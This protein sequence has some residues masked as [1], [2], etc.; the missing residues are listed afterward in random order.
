MW[1]YI[2]QSQYSGF[3]HETRGIY[4]LFTWCGCVVV[5]TA[6]WLWEGGPKSPTQAAIKWGLKYRKV[7]LGLFWKFS[8]KELDIPCPEQKMLRDVASLGWVILMPNWRW[9]WDQEDSISTNY[10]IAHIVSDFDT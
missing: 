5:R 9:P 4:F 6:N 7:K 2:R 10:L 8:F 1:K 3:A